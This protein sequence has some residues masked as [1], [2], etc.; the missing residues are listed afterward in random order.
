MKIYVASPFGFS[1]AGRSF[2]YLELIP[3]LEAAGHVPVD[4]WQLTRADLIGKVTSMPYGLER[5]QAWADLNIEIG[6][7]NRNGIDGSHALLAVLDG[8]DVDSGTAAEIG[9]AYAKGLLIV[10]YRTDF[11]LG[12]DNEGALVNLQVEYFIRASGGTIVN[13]L[14]DALAY[15]RIIPFMSSAVRQSLYKAKRL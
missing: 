3:K 5:K 7:N 14:D 11:R 12:G 2:Y 13:S 6:L 10:G 15:L 9:Y 1:D 4:P 8:S